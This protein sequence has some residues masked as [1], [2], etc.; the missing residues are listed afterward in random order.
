MVWKFLRRLT[1]GA[2]RDGEPVEREIYEGLEILARPRSEGAVWRVAGRIQRVGDDD[3]P[4]HEFVRADTMSSR[5]EAARMTL[6]KARQ[7]IDEQG[8]RL[9]PPS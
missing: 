1:S 4:G 7:L 5:E 9:L 2:A 3:G 6:V 8:A